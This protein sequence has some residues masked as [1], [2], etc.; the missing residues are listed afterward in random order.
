MKLGD[1]ASL[2]AL[3]M[4][5]LANELG[6]PV[7]TLYNYVP[8]KEA[9]H[10]AVVDSVLRPVEV[11]PPAV[12]S[13]E[14]RVRGL[15]RAARQAVRAHR[16]LSFSRH[17]GSSQEAIRLARGAMSILYDGGFAH[18]DAVKAF[19]S[20]FTF[21]LG[22]MELDVLSDATGGQGE[23]TFA[24]VTKDVG[25]SRDELF[26]SGLDAV[27]AGIAATLAAPATG[28]SGEEP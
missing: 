23:A 6:V 22:Q 26:E 12:G 1:G 4:R 5:A 9:L 8:S 18:A 21:M 11:P 3:S 24:G 28:S 14:E 19:A 17:G 13:W 7:M 20:L 2:D 27:I 16:G 15:E 25:L 10:A